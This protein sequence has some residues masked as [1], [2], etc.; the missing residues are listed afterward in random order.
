[1]LPILRRVFVALALIATIDVSLRNMN[2]ERESALLSLVY[3]FSEN[4]C[5]PAVLL[6]SKGSCVFCVLC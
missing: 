4:G 6:V 1:M 5:V 2:F 3:Y